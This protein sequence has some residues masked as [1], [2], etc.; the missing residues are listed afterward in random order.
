MAGGQT[1]TYQITLQ[2]GQF[3]RVVV[4][5]QGIDV[6]VAL[7]APD[8]KQ[9]IEVD[10]PTGA[11]GQ[12]SLSH[13]AAVSGD[14][15]IIIRTVAA[16]APKGTYQVRLEV[17]TS[18]AAQD[19]QRIVAERL[20]VEANQSRK[21]GPAGAQQMIEKAQ[22]A[23]AIWR[24]LADK[25][26]EASTLSLIGFAYSLV[27]KTDQ[28]IEYYEPALA[29]FRGIKDRNGEVRALNNLGIAYFTLSRYEKAI[30]DY[31]QALA[32]FREL[33]SRNGEGVVLS[34]LGN[35]YTNLSRYEKAIEYYQPALAIYRELKDRYREGVVLSNLSIAYFR[36][37]RYEKAI[38]Y[39]EQ[40]LMIFREV[41]DREGEGAALS[42]LG[43]T[44]YGLSRY[45]KAI[46]YQEQALAISRELKDQIGEGYS[47]NSLGDAYAEL[48]RYEKAIEYYNQALAILR[49]LKI[50]YGEGSALN[51]LG[52][53]YRSLGSFDRAT[54]YHNQALR[55]A[56]EVKDPGFEASALNNLMLV[57]KARNQPRLAIFYGKQSVNLYQEIRS[58][59][60]TLE[61]ESQ[62]SFIKSKE[63]TYRDLADL[64]IAQGRLPEA[65]RVINLL[66]EEEYFEFIRRDS[67]AS[68]AAGRSDLTS[69]EAALDK[70]YREIA[71]QLTALGVERSALIDKKS[72][73][74]GEEQRLAKLDSDLAVA[75]Q[76]FQK[77]LDRM[78]TELGGNQDAATKVYQLRES[79]S[80]ME[81]LRALG[82]GTVALYTLVGEEKYRVILMTSDV[83]KGFEYPIKAAD[84]NRKVLAFRE[85]LQ[86]PKL[87][88][89][90]QAQELYRILLG[91][92]TKDLKGA[93]AQTLMWS[94]DGALRYLPMAALHDGEK[95]LIESY[96]QV[97]FTPASRDNLKDAP[98]KHWKALGLGVTKAHGESVPA[99]PGVA[100]EMRGIIHEQ[101]TSVK[102]GV[103]PGTIKLDEFFTQEAMLSGLRQRPPVVHVA[104]HF[105]FRPGNENDSVLLL[106]DGS[107][108]SLAQIKNLPNVFGGV[109]L[110]TLSACNTA[111]GS[112]GASGKE[113]EGFGVLAQ[114]Q[115]AK[116]VLA[117]LWSVFDWSTQ[118]LM[119]RFY[120]IHSARPGMTKAA[121]LRQA[122]LEL[123]HGAEGA[124]ETNVERRVRLPKESR[125]S[126][127]QKIFTP[128]PKAPYAHPYYWAPFILIGNWR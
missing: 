36:L 85:V 108:M 91:P 121:A 62:Q 113:V 31:E 60:R 72:R 104:S 22:Q 20:L 81:T 30:E 46:E 118:K 109:D 119:R 105:Q 98:S 92:L 84:L 86:N 64:L 53:V 52:K 59:I 94:L 90:P 35:A 122:Q 76:A 110:L 57:W 78:A 65:E 74:P 107:F 26:W 37:S 103:L 7:I 97:V 21:R 48:S 87:D 68:G 38:E 47:L 28:A 75:G 13:E 58:N 34:N 49:E 29:I 15:R 128:D 11:F 126:N 14:C 101:G 125:E 16:T 3:L 27:E 89:L 120:Q 24:E 10:Q 44:Y 12:E 106:G 55:I 43:D 73:T 115:G 45:E 77:F 50:R 70:S 61:R 102:G 41:K 71:D 8:G 40:A 42:S 19:K 96:R 100:E 99:L 111:T 25:Y 79:Q 63:E 2:A 117:T 1:H 39:Q 6:A 127:S 66:K 23:L 114:R 51:G 67:S 83:Q 69:E 80:L 32:I 116:A 93:K 33:K 18:A 5:Q 123:L 56:R 124:A 88:P 9:I 17:K 95:Y 54:S 82:A 112:S 4:E